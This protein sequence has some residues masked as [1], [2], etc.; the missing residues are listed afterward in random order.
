[1]NITIRKMGNS[2][3]VILPKA[4]LTQLGLAD[5]VDMQI[6]DGKIILSKPQTVRQGWA[7]AAAAL[8]DEEAVWP[9]FA[10]EDDEQ[11]QW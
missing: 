2:H 7:A 11:W 9:E 3:G 8:A 4:I 6:S 1:M 5:T 10:N